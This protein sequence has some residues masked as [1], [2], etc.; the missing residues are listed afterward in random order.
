MPTPIIANV[1]SIMTGTGLAQSSSITATIVNT[2]GY[3][4]QVPIRIQFSNV[5]ADPIITVYRSTDNG[6]NFDTT[7]IT[8]FSIARVTAAPRLG[9][10]SISLGTGV[11]ALQL[12]NSGPNS[13]QFQIL[14][15]LVVTA[16]S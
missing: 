1:A 13:A 6:T 16:I 15:Q 8:S 3:E 10:A 5:S 9:Q 2:G 12:L 11:Y 7:G 4:V 14:T